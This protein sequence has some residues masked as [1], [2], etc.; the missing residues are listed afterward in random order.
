MTG[1]GRKQAPGF[2]LIELLAAMAIFSF[3]AVMMYGG[4]SWIIVEREI[5]MERQSR[6]ADLQRMVRFINDDLS[7][8]QR[9][10][11]RDELGRDQ[12]P[13][14]L[15]EPGREFIAELSRDGWRNP[16]ALPRSTLQRVQ[17]RLTDRTVIRE[18]WPVLD[19]PLGMEGRV[20]ELFAGVEKFEWEFLDQAGEW[21]PVWPPLIAEAAAPT[22][23]PVAIRYTLE[24]DD[25]GVIERL[26]EVPR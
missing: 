16:A 6:L 23:L 5:I 19:R 17:Y 14:L 8:L 1:F 26:V 18:Y 13:P 25:F 22:D 15:A 9:R 4:T 7:Q 10:P 24:S 21:Q 3:L 20:Q 2:T 11:I 12:L